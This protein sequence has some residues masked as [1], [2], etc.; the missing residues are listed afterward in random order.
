MPNRGNA[1]RLAVAGAGASE[2]VPRWVMVIPRIYVGAVFLAAGIG[3]LGHARE[4]TEP[5][6]SWPTALH[7]QI[8]AW[9][10]HSAWYYRSFELQSVLPHTDLLAPAIGVAHVV[11][12]LALLLGIW[13]RVAAVVAMAL[14]LNYV[15]A[16]GYTVYGAGDPSAYLALLLVVWLGRG[17]ETWGLDVVVA[18]RRSRR[19]VS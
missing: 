6:R 3:Q 2:Q 18:T 7:A 5:G 17:G 14:L 1:V 19:V 11:I 15:A 13:T 9:I 4:W 16:E 10:P 12:G 8:A